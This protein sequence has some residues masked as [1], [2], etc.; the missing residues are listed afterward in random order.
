MRISGIRS[1]YVVANTSGLSIIFLEGP[2]N[3]SVL[4]LNLMEEV[5]LL[6]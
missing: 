3:L 2:L 5:Y 4:S 6:I 1:Q